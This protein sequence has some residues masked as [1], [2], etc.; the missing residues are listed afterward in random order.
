MRTLFI[1]LIILTS[2]TTYSQ[3][4]VNDAFKKATLYIP[5]ITVSGNIGA[6]FETVDH[7]SSFVIDQTT[8][9]KVFTLPTPND[10]TD[11][12]DVTIR[13]IGSA[14]FTMYNI[15]LYPDSFE[16]HLSWKNGEWEPVGNYIQ[17]PCCDAILYYDSD[18][19]AY[20][21]GRINKDEY[22]LTSDSHMEGLGKGIYK[23]VPE[24]YGWELFTTDSISYGFNSL[25]VKSKNTTRVGF[26][27][28]FLGPCRLEPPAV[29]LQYYESD[30]AA[31][32][33]GL[34]VGKSYLLNISNLYG[35]P[36]DW[37]KKITE[38]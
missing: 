34:S 18:T 13:N 19:A 12:D 30:L 29:D 7:Y 11:G 25:I 17:C 21:Q 31:K 36:K 24:N 15:T 27:A 38:P 35:L 10:A 32:T 9:S 6:A 37:I 28:A 16:L 3:Y 20:Y 2:I 1:T 22:Y 5:N 8:S 14:N 4:V 26:D 33:A 23:Q